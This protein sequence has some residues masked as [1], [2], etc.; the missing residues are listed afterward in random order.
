MNK[1]LFSTPL[2]LFV[3]LFFQFSLLQGQ[4]IIRFKS[5][6]A[7]EAESESFK[8]HFKD[9]TLASLNTE[10]VAQLL[11]SKN[12]FSAINLSVDGQEYS[13]SLIAHDIR[14]PHYKLRAWTSQGSIELPRSP[15]KTYFGYTSDGHHDVRITADD[16]FFNALIVLENDE[17]YIEPARNIVPDAPKGLFVIYKSSDNLKQFTEESCGVTTTQTHHQ[18]PDDHNHS[19]QPQGS[20]RACKVLEVAL[21]DDYRMY[22][23]YGSVDDVED[24]NLAVINNVLTNYDFEFNVDLQFDIVEIFVATN[25]SEDPWDDGNNINV[26]LDDFTDWGPSGFS[27][28]HDVAGLW[29]ARNFNGD[30]IGLAWLNAVCTS[31]R[32]HVMEDF[33]S[34]SALLR[35]LQA[36]EMGHNFGAFHDA[37]NSGFIM[38]PSV[39][40]TNLWSNPSINSIDNYINGVSC[41]ATCGIPL[42]PV[43]DF[44]A[45]PTEGCTPLVV[46]FTDLS[47]NSPTSWLWTFVGGTPST[48]TNQNP[49]VTYN[50]PGSFNVTLKATNAQGSNTLTLNNYI[51]VDEAPFADFDYSI[52]EFEVD[53]LNQSFN[54]DTYLWDF[55]DGETSTLTNPLHEYDEDGFYSVTLTAFNDCGSDTYTVTIEIITEPYAFFDSDLVDGCTPLEI[56]FYNLSSDN[57]DDYYWEFPGGSPSSSTAFEPLVLY[58]TPGIYNVSL[59]V[60]N[61]AGEDTQTSSNYITIHP[62][63]IAEFSYTTNGLQV[64]FNSVGSQGDDYY[65]DFGDG[66]F[67]SFQNPTHTY[68]EGGIYQVTLTVTNECSSE[69]L[70]LTIT[71]T[72][73]PQALFTS[74][75]QYGCA[76]LV[77]QYSNLSGGSPTAYSW[78]FEGG[79]PATSNLAN[80][81]VTY[82]TPGLYDVQLTAF[83]DTGS[84]VLSLPDYI[85][86]EYPT[87]SA[88]DYLANGWDVSFFNNSSHAT[89]YYWNFG[90]GAESEASDPFHSYQGDGVYTVTLISE[91]ICGNDTSTTTL[92]IQ[93]PPQAEFS[94]QSS[95]TCKPVTVTFDNNSSPNATS[96]LWSFPG[97]SPT[98]ST[99]ENPVVVY[100]NKGTFNVTLIAYSSG[101]SDTMMM[102]SFITIGDVPNAQ[103]LLATD[104]TTVTFNN[105]SLNA[106]SYQ[107]F[108]GDGETSIEEDPAHTYDEFGTYIVMLISTNQCGSDTS[109]V[110]IVLSTVPNA[111]FGFS[112]H[113]GCAP[114]TVNFVDQSQNNPTEWDWM[115]EGGTP[116]SS[117]EQ[118]PTVTYSIPGVYSVSLLVTNSEGSDA[119]LLDGLIQ[120][121]GTPDADFEHEQN[122]NVITLEYLGTDYDSLRWSFG[123]GRTDT[124]LNP[125]AEYN[126]SGLY[127]ISLIVF[128]QCGFDTASIWVD[129]LITATQDLNANENGW[130]VRPSPFSHEFTLYGEPLT[131]GTA[132]ITLMDV[133]GRLISSDKH[134]IQAGQTSLHFAS[135]SLPQG[136]IFVVIQDE[137][138]RTV[139]KAL[140]Q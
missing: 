16:D 15:N 98:S 89:G 11:Q 28:T 85:E 65:W 3:L 41:L 8:E 129:I 111:F 79:V 50:D 31:I 70:T 40:N 27:N 73:A 46:N 121:G 18:G 29:S 14:A 64:I 123:D 120:V 90:D 9:Y 104:E 97:G 93:T 84:D 49:T 38:A 33:T 140:H 114:F 7:T 60:Y 130:E 99:Q 56:Q 21:A 81:V 128:N 103:F 42:P 91:G 78:V 132:I 82:Y 118:N 124:S 117:T 36:H 72:G 51:V 105:T 95:G 92:T 52:F 139:L 107:W 30:V 86:V 69:E 26:V 10:N 96:F 44:D 13:F 77:V 113:T 61:E 135:E 58:E 39:N 43:A 35:V 83:N 108:F 122:E 80:P 24:H 45:N 131:N 115:F 1:K 110:E 2:L 75:V 71:L 55:G 127:Q 102:N 109:I 12:Y 62:Q 136:L 100:S 48:S 66:S 101:G 59:T 25:Q 67:S 20:S 116:A 88:F 87:T 125:T 6:R 53:F 68:D 4:D 63:A 134:A 94:F 137:Q 47:T 133:H 54:A 138:S 19:P 23:R 32:Y 34:N 17:I 37:P 22:D 112:S 74:D 5:Q 57:S 106:D 126:V 76:P 119:L